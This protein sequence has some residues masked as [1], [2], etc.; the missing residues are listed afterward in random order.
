LAGSLLLFSLHAVWH[1]P[2]FGLEYDVQN[3]LPWLLMLLGGTITS[4]W[5][6]H[7]TNGNLLLPL[8][9]HTSVNVSAKY[10]FNPLFSGADAL[11][12]WWLVAALWLLIACAVLVTTGRDLG[13][14]PARPA[15]AMLVARTVTS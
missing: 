11:R 15:E 6:Y 3:G 2:L 9:F 12:L 14:L 10:L 1:L 13:R 7:R 8:L 5:L 4:T